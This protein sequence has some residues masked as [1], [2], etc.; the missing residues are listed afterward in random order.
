MA[1]ETV[2]APPEAADRYPFALPGTDEAHR[3]LR[4]LDWGEHLVGIDM[5]PAAGNRDVYLY[6]LKEAAKFLQFGAA[7]MGLSTGGKGSISWFE[8]ERF[9][10][11]I[12]DDVGDPEL[13]EVIARDTASETSYHGKVQKLGH[14][15]DARL[16]QLNELID[17]T[18]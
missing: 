14:L 6:S 16:A 3:I 15:V 10:A 1:A 5:N 12:R 9:V 4:E 18:N 11:W 13:A 17:E 8:V 7:G 2:S